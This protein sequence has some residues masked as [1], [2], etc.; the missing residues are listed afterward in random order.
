[1][2]YNHENNSCIWYH[3]TLKGLASK[4]LREG[5]MIN[6]IPTFQS[7]SEPRI[8]VSTHPFTCD[9]DFVT[10]K[11]DLSKFDVKYAKWPFHEGDKPIEKRWQLCIYHNIPPELLTLSS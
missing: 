5:L 8:Y 1:M 6:S 2:I 4:I 10:F 7:S 3:S 11:V 9:K